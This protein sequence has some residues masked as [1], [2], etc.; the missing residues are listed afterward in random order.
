MQSFQRHEIGD[1][2]LLT[3]DDLAAYRAVWRKPVL[4][5]YKDAQIVAMPPPTSGGVALVEILNL[6]EPL[7]LAG[8]GHSSADA[9]HLLGEAGRI[10]WAD[11]GRYLADPDHVPQPTATLISKEYADRRRPEMQ[12]DRTTAKGAGD[13][14]AGSTTHISVVD[15]DG[16]AVAL[17]CTVEQEFGSAVAAP[18]T[19]FVLNNELTDFDPPGAANEPAPGKRPRSSMSPTI[20]VRDGEPALVLGGAGG[21]RIIMGVVTSVLNVLE[22]GMDAVHAVDAERADNR[23]SATMRVEDARLDPAVL[24]DLESRG[25]TLVREGEYAPLPRIQVAGIAEDG[26][27]FAVSDPRTDPGSVAERTRAGAV[28]RR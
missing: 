7:D 11:R 14:G 26:S 4:G 15:R 24:A 18:G 13:V 6:L 12:L 19:G 25:W 2:G 22:F 23:G 16:S 27:A 20:V 9:I 10:A 1:Q 28:R 21:S 8:K 17:T 3:M 5:S